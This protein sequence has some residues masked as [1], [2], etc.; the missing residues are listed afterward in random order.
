MGAG[1]GE[2]TFAADWA[3]L[4]R[5]RAPLDPERREREQHGLMRRLYRELEGRGIDPWEVNAKEIP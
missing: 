5:Y 3:I 2:G 1:Y 4:A